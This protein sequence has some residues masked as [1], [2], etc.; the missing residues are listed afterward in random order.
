MFTDYQRL[1]DSKKSGERYSLRRHLV[2]IFFGGRSIAKQD[3]FC[4]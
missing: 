3:Y 1:P 2:L 4:T